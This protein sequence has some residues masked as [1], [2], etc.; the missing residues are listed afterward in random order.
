[1]YKNSCYLCD[2]KNVS[3]TMNEIPY[4]K[5]CL[6]EERDSFIKYEKS[7]TKFYPEINEIIDSEL[8]KENEDPNFFKN[9]LKN[10]I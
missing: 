2:S 9:L 7:R 6:D 5:S 10:I 3:R 8:E 1:M 4:C